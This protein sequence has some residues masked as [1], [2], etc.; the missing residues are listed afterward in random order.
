MNEKIKEVVTKAKLGDMGYHFEEILFL[1]MRVHYNKSDGYK[2]TNLL[3]TKKNIETPDFN[4][5]L[6]RWALNIFI[7]PTEEKLHRTFTAHVHAKRPANNVKAATIDTFTSGYDHTYSTHGAADTASATT[8]L[9]SAF[10]VGKDGDWERSIEDNTNSCEGWDTGEDSSDAE[11]LI[12]SRKSKA[13]SEESGLRTVSVILILRFARSM[14]PSIRLRNA[15]IKTSVSTCINRT[16]QSQKNTH[17]FTTNI[18]LIEN[19]MET[20]WFTVKILEENKSYKLHV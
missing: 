3:F 4:H 6:D 8:S 11:S 19:K 13:D 17:Q 1:G 20:I 16:N 7:A 18:A 5:W 14:R 10:A 9:S 2:L 12:D 15:K